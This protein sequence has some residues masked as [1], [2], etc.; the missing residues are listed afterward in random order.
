M[1]RSLTLIVGAASLIASARAELQLTPKIVEYK[2]DGA[3]LKHLEFSDG[4]K[5]VPTS[6]LT[7]GTASEALSS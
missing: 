7:A 5:T 6:P 4:D 3:T 2:G 1:V